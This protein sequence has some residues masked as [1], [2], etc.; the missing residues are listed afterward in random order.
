MGRLITFEGGEGAGKSSQL[1]RLAHRLRGEGRDVVTTREPGGCPFAEALRRLLVQ[2]QPGEMTDKTELLLMLA[3]RIEHVRQVIAPALQRGSWVLCD[4]FLDSTLAYQGHGR[5]MDLA[6]LH[7]WH[8]WAL[9]PLLPDRTLLLDVPPE[10]GLQRS[11]R[12]HLESR[13]EQESLAFH[14][15][16]REGFHALAAESPGRIRLID[17]NQSPEQVEQQIGVALGDLFSDA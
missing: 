14:Q 15:R 5:G 11:G 17:A 1:A 7:H 6:L 12:S 2:G 9:G 8:D 16:V 4:R 10:I 3:A 13:F